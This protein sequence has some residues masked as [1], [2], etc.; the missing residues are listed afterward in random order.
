MQIV[1]KDLALD[2]EVRRIES[3]PFGRAPVAMNEPAVRADPKR[4]REQTK[5]GPVD[6][7]I[8]HI[9][10]FARALGARESRRDR[11]VGDSG[12]I[13]GKRAWKIP[14]AGDAMCSRRASVAQHR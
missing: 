12:I 13:K 10:A 14:I 2:R 4:W 5:K 8:D 9:A 1:S 11:L 6:P 3:R 7:V